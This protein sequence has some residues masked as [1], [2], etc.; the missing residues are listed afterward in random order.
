MVP[1][2]LYVIIE[3]LKLGQAVYINKDL[4]M[5][6]METESYAKAANSDLIE[7]LGQVEMVFSDKTGTLTQNKMVL[8]KCQINGYQYGELKPNEQENIDGIALSGLQEI[9][10][11]IKSEKAEFIKYG[12][13]SS[14]MSTI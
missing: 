8:K 14:N 10:D 6:D 3:I 2:S 9:R 1:I 13:N 7:E 4:Q 5:Y 11:A 12:T